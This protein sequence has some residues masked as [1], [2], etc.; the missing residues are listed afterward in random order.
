MNGASVQEKRLLEAI[1][2]KEAPHALMITAPERELA[3]AKAR[4]FARLMLCLEP[5]VEGPCG[6][7]LGCRLME[8]ESHPDFTFLDK[9]KDRLI[10]VERVREEVVNDL[11]IRPQYD[12]GKV[13][14]IVADDLNEQ[15]QNALLK[16]LEEPPPY[17]RFLLAAAEPQQ[18]L[19]T[20]HSRVQ[21]LAL[22]E[23]ET[24]EQV[25]LNP[26]VEKL[27]F[28][29]PDLSIAD[30]LCEGLDLLLEE[31]D[32]V[33]HILERYQSYLRDLAWLLQGGSVDN[34][35]LLN[36]D[37]LA[38]LQKLNGRL[39]QAGDPNLAQQKLFEL[40]ERTGELKRAFDVNTSLEVSLGQYLLALRRGFHL[41][42][43]I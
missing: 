40:G 33:P 24:A 42:D 34:G 7:C 13:Y 1:V 28:A 3:I 41:Q 39:I 36:P 26:R 14:L 17:G 15:G 23:G 32:M 43:I 11:V 12:S 21:T 37:D 38:A 2:T 6:T 5:R 30:V 8:S 29:L 27:F 9:G 19:E 16:S 31:K 22:R 25:D 10:K 35:E 4:E 18:L 20:I